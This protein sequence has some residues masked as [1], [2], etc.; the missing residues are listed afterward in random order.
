MKNLKQKIILFDVD[1]VLIELPYYFSEQLEREWYKNAK[2]I[3]N[4]FFLKYNKDIT[5]WRK[6][7]K[8][9]ILPYLEEIGWTE[10]ID[11]FLEKQYLFES[12]FLNIEI[13]EI[14]KNL[15]EDW[16]KCYLATSQ[17]KER[18]QYFLNKLNFRNLFDWYFISN[19]IWYRK[20]NDEFWEKL[21]LSF[22]SIEFKEIYFFDDS[23]NNIE[24]A[25]RNWIKSFLYSD[26]EKF[27]EELDFII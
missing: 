13:L 2:E 3:F 4:K 12:Q 26:F 6:L 5:E 16:I 20:E 21:L 14:I 8:K 24:V 22:W 10:S 17:E 11:K 19:E 9:E 7:I 23:K 15:R 18:W 27:K 1:W 25:Q